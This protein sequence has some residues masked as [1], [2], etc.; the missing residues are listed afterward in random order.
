MQDDVG[1]RTITKLARHVRPEDRVAYFNIRYN[2]E[3][4]YSHPLHV[5]G[6]RNNIEQ[7]KKLLELG[8][9][10]KA[11][12]H[13]LTPLLS[14]G[15][16]QTLGAIGLYKVLEDCEW[17]A[18][19]I[20][21]VSQ[22]WDVSFLILRE[23]CS[24]ILAQSLEES[25]RAITIFHLAA[26][27][28]DLTIMARMGNIRPG[29]LD[30]RMPKSG[31][32]A[33]HLA[34]QHERATIF[35]ILLP[36]STLNGI[37]NEDGA[38]V[39]HFAIEEVYMTTHAPTRRWLA[40]I[41]KRL[42]DQGADPNE[43]KSDLLRRTPLLLATEAVRYDWY[44]VWREVKSIIDLLIQKGANVNNPDST[45]ATPLVTVLNR[46]ISESDHGSMQTMFLDLIQNHGA[47]INFRPP[48]SKSITFRLIDAPAMATL[49]KKVVAL[50]GTIA[51]DEVPEKCEY[52]IIGLHGS[53]ISDQDINRAY[54]HAMC[55]GKK[56]LFLRVRGSGRPYT[57]GDAK[58]IW[59]T[60][61][62]SGAS[63]PKFTSQ[64]LQIDWR[65][66]EAQ[67]GMSFLHLVVDKLARKAEYTEKMA[68]ADVK[69]LT[70]NQRRWR[71][72]VMYRDPEGKTALDRVTDMDQQFPLLVGELTKRYTAQAKK[73]EL[74][75][76]AR[77][78]EQGVR[79]V[80]QNQ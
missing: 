47:N 24:P 49:C 66:V 78:L 74:C 11:M 1:V 22:N 50:G 52:D 62:Q 37:Y 76:A 15:Q 35:D 46:V 41:V 75:Q 70:G 58:L 68:V 56:P 30:I 12:C 32:T 51:Q 14:G 54:E 17:K 20:P 5:A 18:T 43:P 36:R 8:A 16:L 72:L 63:L 27:Q 65:C 19:L 25:D 73:P 2:Y 39:L 31:K 60:L 23:D 26:L 55:V 59:R 21:I 29:G 71:C 6:M 61:K 44:R 53:E 10:A 48:G 69:E 79:Q 67:T 38:N 57:G 42:L 33:L 7:A 64:L 4:G 34:I 45:G 13:N 28:N 77:D 9:D 40:Q 3:G 80:Q